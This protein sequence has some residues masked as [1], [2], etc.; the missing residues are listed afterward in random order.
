M[1]LIFNWKIQPQSLTH[2]AGILCSQGGS[3]LPPANLA[4]GV[5]GR[6]AVGAINIIH[7]TLHKTLMLT[8]YCDMQTFFSI[9]RHNQRFIR[10]GG[11]VQPVAGNL[12]P[13]NFSY[14]NLI[15][16][17]GVGLCWWSHLGRFWN[18][19]FSRPRPRKSR[20]WKGLS[21]QMKPGMCRD[22]GA[23]GCTCVCTPDSLA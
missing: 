12:F 19:R 18:W 10:C 4:W 23:L 8:A 9:I 20:F 15:C 2:D 1:F 11:V 22:H 7:L 5:V 21:I 6:G 17:P 14:S 13:L 3:L 16:E